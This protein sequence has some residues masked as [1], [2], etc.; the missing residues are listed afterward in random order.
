MSWQKSLLNLGL[1]LIEKPQMAN[2]EGP[3]SMRHAFKLKAKIMLHAPCSMRN[4]NEMV[5]F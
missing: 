2:A 1:R 3:N 5:Q 4:G